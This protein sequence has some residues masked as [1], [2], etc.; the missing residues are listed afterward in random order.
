MK[1][2]ET[3][4]WTSCAVA[5]GRSAVLRGLEVLLVRLEHP[6]HLGAR[7]AER[8]RDLDPVAAR[9]GDLERRDAELA[10]HDVVARDRELGADEH[11][12]HR[13]PAAAALDEELLGRREHLGRGLARARTPRGRRG[14][15]RC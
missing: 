8:A 14:S 15:R 3:A 10:E 1:P 4:R 13:Q 5:P 7:R 11:H 12:V 6:L 9:A 2:F